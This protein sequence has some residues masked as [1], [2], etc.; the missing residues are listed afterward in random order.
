MVGAKRVIIIDDDQNILRIFASLL[1]RKGYI[2][3][4]AASGKEALEK[5]CKE[6]Y[7]VALIDVMLP[8]ANGIDLLRSIPLSTKKIVITGT[9]TEENRRKAT[10][11]GV[12][13]YLLKPVK[14]EKLLEIIR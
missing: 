13:M 6:Q 5:L 3:D 8:D 11:E 10:S 12:D 14:P 2:V 9:E 7:D 1:Q 4:I